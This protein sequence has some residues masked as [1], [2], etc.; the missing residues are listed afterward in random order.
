[1]NCFYD[2][3][4]CPLGTLGQVRRQFHCHG[5]GW[6][7]SF[8]VQ[9]CISVISQTGKCASLATDFMGEN[10]STVGTPG[11]PQHFCRSVIL[12]AR[13]GIRTTTPT[14]PWAR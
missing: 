5:T 10:G 2:A 8:D 7:K 4:T 6:H 3:I 11:D 12:A 9:N 14:I 1:V 13:C